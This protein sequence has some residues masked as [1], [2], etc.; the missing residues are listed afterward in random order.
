[1]GKWYHIGHS[2]VIT[3]EFIVKGGI[4]EKCVYSIVT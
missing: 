4:I 3:D 2:L 1:M